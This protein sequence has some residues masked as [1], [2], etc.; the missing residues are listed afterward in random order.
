MT[1]SK[2]C[3]NLVLGCV[4]ESD[5]SSDLYINST[6]TSILLPNR[7]LLP[8]SEKQYSLLGLNLL[9]LLAQNRIS[10]FHTELESLPSDELTRNM[11]IRHTVEV[12]QSLMEGSYGKVVHSRENVPAAEYA[13]FM[14][15]LMGTIRYHIIL[16]KPIHHFC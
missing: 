7:S 2:R 6:S 1:T 8:L 11:Y 12:E 9:N 5:T 4:S 13:F 10:E 16:G 3:F 15:I 14:D